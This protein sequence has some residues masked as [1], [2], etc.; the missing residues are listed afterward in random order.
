MLGWIVWG[1]GG[2][3]VDL[4]NV[5]RCHCATCE[6]VRPFKVLLQYRYAHVYWIF[7]WV[8]E[9]KYM[10]VCDI[11][12]RGWALKT[13]EVE[14]SFSKHPI[15]FMR[16][17]GWTFLA[18]PFVSLIG[19]AHIASYFE[20]LSP[21]SNLSTTASAQPPKSFRSTSSPAYVRPTVADNG[22]LFPVA[23]GYIAGYPRLLQDGYSSVTVDNTQNDSDVFVKLFSLDSTSSSIPAQV[24]FVRARELFIIENMR[25][26]KYDVRYRVLDSG[27]L[28]RTDSFDLQEVRGQERI[29]HSTV[30]LTLYQVSN[31]NMRVHP[32]SNQEF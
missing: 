17:Y 1:G 21:T 9:K 6:R 24:F 23:S 28:S 31:G 14:K 5:K 8:S 29:G 30:R 3:S 7:A 32:I 10:L 27:V 11:C 22:H 2:D 19:F 4:G 25:A 20:S 15:P 13:E 26:G 18:V 16:R 12:H